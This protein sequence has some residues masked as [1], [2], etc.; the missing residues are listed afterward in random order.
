VTAEGNGPGGFGVVQARAGFEPLA[1][2]VHQE[3]TAIGYSGLF[4]EAVMRSKRSS[5]GYP[6]G[7]GLQGLE[8]LFFVG[9]RAGEALWF[10]IE[11]IEII[12]R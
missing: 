2:P 7:E 6:T 9:G 11:T 1:V 8:A 3:M 10:F 12:R 4:R 5:R